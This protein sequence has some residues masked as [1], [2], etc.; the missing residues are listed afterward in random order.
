VQATADAAASAAAAAAADAAT[1]RKFLTAV[2]FV[3]WSA[4]ASFQL[5]FC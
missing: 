1:A 2:A 3:G 5:R 4:L